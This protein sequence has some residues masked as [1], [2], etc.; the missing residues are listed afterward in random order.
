M[1]YRRRG[2]AIT[3]IIIAFLLAIALGCGY[4]F[5]K[6]MSD[7]KEADETYEK[8]KE[9]ITVSNDVVEPEDDPV[10]TYPDLKINYD[11]LMK[12]NGDFVGVIYLP[13]LDLCYP[14][15]HS[16]DNKDYLDTSFEGK[17]L[18]AGCI[19][20]DSYA[21]PDFTD[22]NSFIFGHNMKD[23]SMFGSLKRMLK[24]REGTELCEKDP[25]IYIYTPEKVLKYHIFSY[26]LIATDDPG[27]DFAYN[28]VETSWFNRPDLTP[29]LES[30][31]DRYVKEAQERSEYIPSETE[32]D[33]FAA[34]PKLLSLST[35]SGYGHVKFFLLHSAL[36]G[37]ANTKIPVLTNSVNSL[38]PMGKPAGLAKT[39]RF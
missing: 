31:Y 35:C 32:A 13:A 39:V 19:F 37:E 10:I 26:T 15:A 4:Y 8:I 18:F 33:D 3:I 27:Y 9:N 17:K 12:I 6:D 14:V 38:I 28:D 20:L 30:V 2:T 24:E 22:Y 29:Q 25:Y 5:L 11:N 16:K 34:R 1:R 36:I 23:G 21:H 7:Y